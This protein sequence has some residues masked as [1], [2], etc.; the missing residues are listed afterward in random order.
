MEG[1]ELFERAVA[2]R[3]RLL[4]VERLPAPAADDEQTGSAFLLT[5]DA[6]RILLSASTE[7]GALHARQLESRDEVPSGLV[8]AVEAEPWWRLLGSPITGA[9][10]EDAQRRLRL[11]I[12]EDANAP[13]FALVAL[14]GAALRATLGT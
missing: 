1:F 8:T 5:L 13:R 11:Q 2:A 7:T 9:R 10:L 3:A 14:R 6:G 4:S 12:R